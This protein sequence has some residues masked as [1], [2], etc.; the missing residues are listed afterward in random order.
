MSFIAR[1]ITEC[2]C[3]IC[4]DMCKRSSCLPTPADT[5]R[6]I[7]AG[8]KE[9]LEIGLCP[10]RLSDN[11]PIPIVAPLETDAGCIFQDKDGLCELHTSG[12]KPSEGKMAIHDIADDG[13]RRAI[14][15]TWITPL[16][17]EVMKRF[18]ETGR[19]VEIMKQML[20]FVRTKK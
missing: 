20:P 18:D 19:I 11:H 14:S 10:D 5:I 4:K 15:Y 6:L 17:I 1:K 3:A 9:K 12:L 13:L 8:Y 7:E 2:S 16:G